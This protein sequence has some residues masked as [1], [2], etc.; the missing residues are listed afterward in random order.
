VS[1]QNTGFET[2]FH[3]LVEEA[4]RQT[5]G[6]APT[7]DDLAAYLDGEL[8]PGEEE[9]LQNRLVLDSEAMQTVLDLVDPTR[10]DAAAGADPPVPTW[11]SIRARLNAPEEPEVPRWPAWRAGV[12]PAYRWA[13]AALL[14][15]V[16][17]LGAWIAQLRRV[18]SPAS[19]RLNVFHW[20]I[21]PIDASLPRDAGAEHEVTQAPGTPMVLV[22]HLGDRGTF[23]DYSLEIRDGDGR[24]HWRSS[25]LIP[26][27]IGTFNVE[28]PSGFL[29]PGPY[30]LRLYG[31][32][33]ETGALLANYRLESRHP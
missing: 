1:T 9:R 2:D 27:P 31:G 22:L 11:Q 14:L 12:H 16:V 20:E 8:S 7:P 17:G 5:A 19:P 15:L 21:L 28:L 3:E 30:E 29:P 26:S 25:G 18:S 23:S 10:L 32:E 4:Q 24:L 13:V 6:P 33:S